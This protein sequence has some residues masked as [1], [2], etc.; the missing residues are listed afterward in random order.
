MSKKQSKQNTYY[1]DVLTKFRQHKL[2]MIGAFVLLFGV[3]AVIFLPIILQLDPYASAGNFYSPPTKE[4]WF[5]TDSVGRDLFARVLHGGRVSL[6]VGL[7]SAL[8]SVLIGVPMGL[9]AGYFRGKAE[10]IIMRL[11]DM[12]MS[13]PSMILILALAAV[14]GSSATVLTLILGFLGWP[15][16]TRLMYANVI[17]IKEKEYVESAVAIGTRVP[18]ILTKYII[19]NAISPILI[20]FTFRTAS[21]ILQESSLSFLGLG[22]PMPTPSWGNIMYEAQSITVLSERPWVWLPSG[23]LL[24]LTVLSINFVG[25]GLR[26]ALD[27]KTT[28]TQSK[29]KKQKKNA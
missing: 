12:L 29:G 11:V 6:F 27:P 18:T 23:I 24:L 14:I 22:V 5:G 25:D 13:F 19:P 9:I 20:S 26:D 4:F 3:L 2:A 17:S 28:I 8:I 1:G 16:I 7:G 21:A 10:T 15:E